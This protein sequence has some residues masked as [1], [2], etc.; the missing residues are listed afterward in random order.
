MDWSKCGIDPPACNLKNYILRRGR[1]DVSVVWID[2]F[3]DI[4]VNCIYLKHTD[5]LPHPAIMQK[6]R[7]FLFRKIVVF[8]CCGL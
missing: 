7:E 2:L 3:N 4:F 5:S 8:Y 1:S 6:K